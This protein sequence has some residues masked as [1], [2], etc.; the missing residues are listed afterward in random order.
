MTNRKNLSEV[1]LPP[2]ATNV[3]IAREKT[4]TAGIV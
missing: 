4:N 2:Q 3:A 1:A